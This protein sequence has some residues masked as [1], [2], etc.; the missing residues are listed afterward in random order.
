MKRWMFIVPIVLVVLAAGAFAVRYYVKAT[1]N[2]AAALT[3][4]EPDLA[5]VEDG[6]YLGSASITMPVGTAAA[7]VEA[8]VRVTVRDHRYTAV[9]VL[10]PSDAVKGMNDFAQIV[11]QR[12]SVRPD[13]ISGATVTKKIILMAV[14]N[15]VRERKGPEDGHQQDLR[16]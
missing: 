7:N 15:A 11:I 3:W 1:H 2:W 13:A 4:S 8:T 9:E 12:Q 16:E 14:V 6:V 10:G 5:T